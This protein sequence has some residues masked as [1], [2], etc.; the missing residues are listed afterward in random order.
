VTFDFDVSLFSKGLKFVRRYACVSVFIETRN[1]PDNV[2]VI[3]SAKGELEKYLP[4]RETIQHRVEELDDLLK[5]LQETLITPLKRNISLSK[6]QIE[7]LVQSYKG[8]IQKLEHEVKNKMD[9]ATKISASNANLNKIMTKETE[10]ITTLNR[11][12]DIFPL[13]SKLFTRFLT[14]YSKFMEKEA[15][16][17]QTDLGISVP[18]EF[19]C[20]IT[21][22][23][24]KC[25]AI[26]DCGHAFE[27]VAISDYVNK[28]LQQG[29]EALCPLCRTSIQDVEFRSDSKFTSQ[30]VLWKDAMDLILVSRLSQSLSKEKS[31]QEVQNRVTEEIRSYEKRMKQLQA[32]QKALC[33][34]VET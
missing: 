13:Q 10:N 28:H 25:P 11:L 26:T 16:Q 3:V 20:P 9:R 32:L 33:D 24:M 22:E 34:C 23:I 7:T 31:Y 15:R 30:I 29:T 21:M 5:H 4:Q 19:Y 27:L 12:V 18:D 2:H 6:K 17:V 1:Q 14:L 8:R